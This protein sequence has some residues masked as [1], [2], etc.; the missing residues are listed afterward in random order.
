MGIPKFYR[1]LSERYALVNSPLSESPPPDVDNLYL[2]L[3]GV[4]HNCTHANN[5][6]VAAKGLDEDQVRLSLSLCVSL[7]MC[8]LYP[9]ED[10]SSGR[11]FMQS[12]SLASPP[13]SISPRISPCAAL[14]L[15][16]G[17]VMHVLPSWVWT[18]TYTCAHSHMY[19]CD[20][21]CRRYS[22][23]LMFSS[24]SCGHRMFSILRSMVSPRARR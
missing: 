8:I 21:S 7:Y 17:S 1:W 9:T 19:L 18:W 3:N 24:S 13:L 10:M 20:R 14:R 23:T 11:R 2:D 15:S 4:L 5:D 16:I 12:V 6:E 22:T